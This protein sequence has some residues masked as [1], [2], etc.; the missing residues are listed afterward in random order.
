MWVKMEKEIIV[1]K[2][3]EKVIKIISVFEHLSTG[4][5]LRK[6]CNPFFLI[7]SHLIKVKAKIPTHA[8]F[9][10][11]AGK[12]LFVMTLQISLFQSYTFL[13]LQLKSFCREI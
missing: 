12:N 9:M 6:T 13:H 3:Q 11:L 4:E 7:D 1:A 10:I 8:L 2:K 5:K